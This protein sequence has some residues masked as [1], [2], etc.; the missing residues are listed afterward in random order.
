MSALTLPAGFGL[1]GLIAELSPQDSMFD[2]GDAHYL[3]VGLSA[4][5][6]I[7]AAL[8]GAPEPRRVLD[9]PCGF[10]RVTRMLRARYPH[11]QITVCDLDRAAV[12]FT[13][14]TFS[15]EGVYSSQD[16][17]HLNLSGQFDL[18]W[19]GSLL[20][21][22][23]ERQTRDFL[24][25]AVRHMAPE[26]RLIVTTHGEYVA[27]RLRETT[28]GLQE[29][30][31]RGLIAQYLTQGYGYRGYD[32]DANY[33]ISLTARVWFENLLAGGALRIQSFQERGWDCHQDVLVLRRAAPLKSRLWRNASFRRFGRNDLAPIQSAERQRQHDLEVVEGFDEDWYCRNFPDVAAAKSEG[34]YATGLAHYQ[35]YGWK[36]GRPPFDPDLSYAKRAK[37]QP[38]A[39][40]DGI[41]RVSETWS[42]SPEDSSQK[43]GWYW[44]AHPSVRTRSNI[45][46]SS[47]ADNDA[48]DRLRTLLGERGWSMPIG[49]SVSLGCGF[50][51]LE[52]DLTARGLI[53]QI[54]A[55]DVAAGAIAE[56]QRQARQAGLSNIRYHVADLDRIELPPASLDAVFAHSSVH[57]VE[58]LE[59]LYACLQRALRPGGVFH[60]HEFVGPNRFQWT[61]EQL[62][63]A[64]TFLEGLPPR[65]RRLPDG[66][67]KTL[68]RP[69]IEEMIASDP[70]ES[71][72]S[73]ELV[74]ALRPYFD[75]VE[76]RRLGGALAHNALGGIAQNFDPESAEDDALLR[77][78]FDMEDAAMAEGVIG[79][80]FATITA[81]PKPVAASP[82]QPRRNKKSTM[83]SPLSTRMASLF[84]PARRLHEAINYLNGTV[85]DLQGNYLRL[86]AEIAEL[87]RQD[88][89]GSS[90]SPS[91]V[92]TVPVSADSVLDRSTCRELGEAASR[93]LPFLPGTFEIDGDIL[94]VSGYCGA[95]DGIT[96]N[97]AFFINGQKIEQIE[98]PIE[99][100]ELK[101]RFPDVPGMGLVFKARVELGTLADSH[102]PFWR[103]DAAPTGYYNAGDW[104]RAIHYMN[105]AR[106]R[107]AFPPTDNIR[108]VIGD[109]SV[110]RFAM[111]G[112]IIFKNA[113]HYFAEQ[114]LS[115]S[116][117]PR[118][119]DWGCGA[120]R[121]ARYLLG[122][123]GCDVTGVDIDADNIG[124]CR[125]TYTGGAFQVVP[126]RPPTDLP[127]GSFDLVFGLSVVTHLQEQDQFLW[128]QELQRVT[129]PGALVL[130]S[131][132]GPT[133]FSYNKF[134]PHL[135]R[136][137]QQ[138][139]Y[140]DL[141]RDAALDAVVAD[142]EYYRAA[143]HSRSYI[144]E[145]WSRYFDVIAIV[146]AIAALQDFVVL[147][148]R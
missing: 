133:Q 102:S 52:R 4:L 69:T 9:I 131:V 146:D 109:T 34:V 63:L 39:W 11:A 56:A 48:Y 62:R 101:S 121:L 6:I 137:L 60:L 2:G 88:Q 132:Q 25:F 97:M 96:S 80:D 46:A 55:Y 85:G 105:P 36:E 130:L 18:I 98:Y 7:E 128:L 15:A 136:R 35:Q 50:G 115:W 145:N 92:A 38:G 42:V 111:G 66:Q 93:H 107:F 124:W 21:H 33:G 144:V 37:A 86:A 139:G 51:A 58:R 30:A 3:D 70:S 103:F 116:D 61:D 91:V 114:G 112:A 125:T 29:E 95:P 73:S 123:S 143:M 59:S 28:Y 44:M 142:K 5:K 110:E 12:D 47:R 24:D 41:D 75:I 82:P 22:L 23:P 90:A 106:E 135:F 148:R 77:T 53:D 13:A 45:L 64:N 120:G 40:V 134:P 54:D 99:D 118:I 19:V 94:S 17:R 16:F 74:A 147:R 10:G 127:S 76:Y 79:S 57:H 71:V 104:R 138:E 83:S 26:S 31:A 100:A 27:N 122:E 140:I 89:A 129:R 81:F 84:P 32:G 126:L 49:R 67:M 141:C 65:L 113:E 43:V 14:A 108:R 117:F 20:T 78:L 119:L 87:R 72:R 8:I 1:P 68:R